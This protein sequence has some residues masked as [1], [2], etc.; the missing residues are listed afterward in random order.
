MK[1]F[2]AD[3]NQM[4]AFGER[5]AQGVGRS[6]AGC[7]I[8]LNGE[9]G[10]GKTTLTRGLLRGL[11]HQGA[12]KSPTFTLVEPYELEKRRVFHFDLYRLNDPEELE[13]VGIR[14]YFAQGNVIVV[15]W[16][17]YGAGVLPPP[18]LIV[19][20]EYRDKGREV[21]VQGA[22]PR[23]DSLLVQLQ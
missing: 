10:A 13:Y 19:V 22:S 6:D 16:P 3:E 11:G 2:L 8:Y 5:L 21:E 7:V 14:D 9:L 12:V 23:G 18:D 4:L 15:E 17:D 1:F 20:I